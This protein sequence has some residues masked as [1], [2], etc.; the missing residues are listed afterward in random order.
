MLIFYSFLAFALW[1]AY[2]TDQAFISEWSEK[3]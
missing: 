3:E 2:K 1:T